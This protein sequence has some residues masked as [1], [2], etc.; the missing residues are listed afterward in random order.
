MAVKL[1]IM[2]VDG[3]LTDGKIYMGNQ[4]EMMKAFSVKD[5]YAISTLLPQAGIKPVIL[6][7][8]SSDIVIMRAKELGIQYVIQGSKDKIEDLKS[9]LEKEAIDWTET[10]YIG[11]DLNDF[12]CMSKAGVKGCPCDAAKE[13][14]EI[15]DFISSKAGGDGAV[16]EF[17]E[18][19]IQNKKC[20]Q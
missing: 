11:D 18:W 6:T 8:R 7:G 14:R 10:A 17:I 4:G 13:I 19:I 12:G 16:R 2:D 15:A 3:T 5:G 9:I 20:E 1:L